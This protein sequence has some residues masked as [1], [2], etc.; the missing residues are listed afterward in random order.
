MLWFARSNWCDMKLAASSGWFL[1][2]MSSIWGENF[3]NIPDHSVQ[4]FSRRFFFPT[5]ESLPMYLF[6]S[7]FCTSFFSL[8]LVFVRWIYSI[9]R[10]VCCCVYRSC[11][12]NSSG[13]TDSAWF[14]KRSETDGRTTNGNWQLQGYVVDWHRI[15]V[16]ID[17]KTQNWTTVVFLRA[18]WITQRTRKYSVAYQRLQSS[19]QILGK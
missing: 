11:D 8:S 10:F 6:I 15:C 14:W 12:A 4:W 2:K 3:A 17:A 1:E 13:W 19:Q 18:L 5:W 9:F 7:K 16:R